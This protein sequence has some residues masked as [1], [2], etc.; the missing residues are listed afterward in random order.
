L[1]R[2]PLLQIGL[3]EPPSAAEL[4]RRDLLVRREPVDRALA[5]L[6][7][8]RDFIQREDFVFCVCHRLALADV[9]I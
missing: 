8:G 5:R 9:E 3:A 6:Q 1:L 2:N 7:V 4:E